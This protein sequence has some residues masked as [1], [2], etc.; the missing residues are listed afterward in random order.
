MFVSNNKK[1]KDMTIVAGLLTIGLMPL[2]A[3]GFPHGSAIPD[4]GL[5]H[6]KRQ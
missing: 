4:G 3:L 5:T 2:S 6:S 1:L